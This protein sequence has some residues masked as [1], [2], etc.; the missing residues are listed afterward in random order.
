[1]LHCATSPDVRADEN[2][3]FYVDCKVRSPPKRAED[4]ALAARLW[5]RSADW[6]GAF[7]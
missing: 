2:G 3:A 5:E 4:A 6:T 7:T 1:V